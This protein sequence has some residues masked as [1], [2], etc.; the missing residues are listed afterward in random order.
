MPASGE[1]VFGIL[2]ALYWLVVR[3]GERRPT[4]LV[5]DDA[6]WADAPSLR[7]LAHLQPRISELPV[8]LVMGARPDGDADGL[9]GVVAGRSRDAGAAT[10]VAERCRGR[11]A[12][13]GSVADRVA[14]GLSALPGAHRRATRCS[15]GELLRAA[16]GLGGTLD[17]GDVGDAAAAAARRLE[18]SVRNRLAALPPPA[19]AMA[20]AVAVFEDEVPL[21]LAAALAQVDPT[22]AGAAVD[23]LVRA[24][25]L[26]PRDPLGFH[27]P[28]LR[29]AVYGAIPAA[30]ARRDAR[31]G[32]AVVHGVGGRR[33]SRCART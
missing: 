28:L 26:A 22:A 20:E 14:G 33:R 7:F 3:L 23:E 8:G 6:Q 31:P 18:R 15:C 10:A 32:G 16:D 21:H 1:A 5:V 25:V 9:L 2:H 27:H 12:G 19:R 4:V 29:A 30:A 24:D 17:V 11:E 13:A